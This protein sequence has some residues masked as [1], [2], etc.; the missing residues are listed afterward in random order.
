[1]K[2]TPTF[3]SKVSNVPGNFTCIGYPASCKVITKCN[4]A[5]NAAKYTAGAKCGV[6]GKVNLTPLR[7]N[8]PAT[9]F[10]YVKVRIKNDK[11]RSEK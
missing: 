11:M 9:A 3:T 10:H 5:I 2:R 1:M 6:T 7:W 4:K 8:Q